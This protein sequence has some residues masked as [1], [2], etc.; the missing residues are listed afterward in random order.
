MMLKIISKSYSPH[1]LKTTPAQHKKGDF[2]R[3]LMW[4]LP[5]TL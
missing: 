5:K 2:K 1:M 3:V 4:Y